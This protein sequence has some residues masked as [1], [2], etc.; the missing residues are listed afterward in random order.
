[1]ARDERERVARDKAARI[2][3]NLR[4]MLGARR[5]AKAYRAK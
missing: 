2:I 3:R 1:M 4:A 5:V